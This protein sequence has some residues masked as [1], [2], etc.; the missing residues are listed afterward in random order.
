MT[1]LKILLLNARDL[2]DSK[3]R[4]DVFQYLRESKCS[5]YCIQDF[6]C[7][8]ADEQM[9]ENEWDCK[10][11]FS[12][13]AS[14]SRGVAVLLNNILDLKV[15]GVKRDNSG[16]LLILDLE[17]C[18]YRFTLVNLYGPNEDSPEFYKM[19]RRPLMSLK[20]HL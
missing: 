13:Y 19:Y 7:I 5:I 16:N 10:A 6:H 2:R 8:Q 11:Y 18:D 20:M 17:T 14:N 3:K 1:E 9:Y 15:H 12:S 4:R